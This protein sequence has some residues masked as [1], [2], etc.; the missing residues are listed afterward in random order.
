M[1]HPHHHHRHCLNRQYLRS[2]TPLFKQIHACQAHCPPTRV[3][4]SKHTRGMK[5][6]RRGGSGGKAQGRGKGAAGK[7][8][9]KTAKR[10]ACDFCG[11]CTSKKGNLTRHMRTHTGERPYACDFCPYRASQESNLITHIR[12]HTGEKPYACTLCDYRASRK[13]HLRKHIRRRHDG[14]DM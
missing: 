14:G 3:K 12:T 8:K 2:S 7:K 13:S 4:G 5:R 1:T 10:Y 11:Y 9:L 6:K